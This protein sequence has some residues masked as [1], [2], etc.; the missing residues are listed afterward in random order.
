MCLRICVIEGELQ[1]LG[2]EG[3]S[4]RA[5]ELCCALQALRLRNAIQ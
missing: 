1:A 4:M 5:A 3:D 2:F